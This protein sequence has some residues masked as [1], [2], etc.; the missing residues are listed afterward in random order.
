[1]LFLFR[2][3]SSLSL[4]RVLNHSIIMISLNEIVSSNIEMLKQQEASLARSLDFVRKAIQLF[5]SQ[6]GATS[7]PIGGKRGRPRGRKA[8][9]VALKIS[10]PVKAAKGTPRPRR[11][12]GGK[13]IDRIIA[14]L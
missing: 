4:R 9:A 6:G 8:A 14:V 2:R 13:H 7:S 3:N 12:K 5:E 1:M 10:A 11:R